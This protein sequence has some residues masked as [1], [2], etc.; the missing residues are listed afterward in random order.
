MNSLLVFARAPEPGKVKTRLASQ[1]GAE[2]AARLYAAL[3]QDTLS[4]CALAATHYETEV[5]VCYTPHNAFA[6]GAYSLSHLWQGKSWSQQGTDLGEKMRLAFAHYFIQCRERI[7]LIGSDM[8]TLNVATLWAAFEA[9]TTHDLVFGPAQD[10]GFYL[11]GARAPLPADIFQS[12]IWS[13]E[14]TLQGVLHNAARLNLDVAL[15]PEGADIDEW[16]DVQNFVSTSEKA[17]H[18]Q[19]ALRAENLL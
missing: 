2:A 19:G 15:L 11:I 18:F 16:C 6:P 8:P 9:L 14:S 4:T 10:G 7:V 1:I 12:V 17:L 13:H 5:V 3:L